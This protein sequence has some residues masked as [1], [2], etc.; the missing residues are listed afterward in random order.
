MLV[1]EAMPYV[2]LAGIPT[3]KALLVPFS[4][5]VLHPYPEYAASKSGVSS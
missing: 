5:H 3:R 2:L 4:P 1:L